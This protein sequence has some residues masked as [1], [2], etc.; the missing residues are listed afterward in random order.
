VTGLTLTTADSRVFL[1]WNVNREAVGRYIVY[2]S[3]TLRGVYEYL[4]TV[5]QPTNEFEDTVRYTDDGVMA[6][7]YYYYKVT[8][9]SIEGLEG[10]FPPMPVWTRVAE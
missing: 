10:P 8:G 1:T 5:S 3:Q 7:F 9:V 4:A 2:R 6:G